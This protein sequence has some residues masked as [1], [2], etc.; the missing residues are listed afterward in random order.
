MASCPLAFCH[1]GHF[2]SHCVDSAAFPNYKER[3]EDCSFRPSW[4]HYREGH[5]C[6]WDPG[7]VLQELKKEQVAAETATTGVGYLCFLSSSCVLRRF[8]QRSDPDTVPTAETFTELMKL[9]LELGRCQEKKMLWTNSARCSQTTSGMG[10]I[11]NFVHIHSPWFTFGAVCVEEIRARLTNPTDWNKEV[12]QR[13]HGRPGGGPPV[14]F[15][16]TFL[17]DLSGA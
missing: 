14:A 3:K 11:T 13:W 2:A 9:L 15:S 1:C 12:G 8:L 6:P 10:C 4:A 16:T 7:L 17:P 5:C